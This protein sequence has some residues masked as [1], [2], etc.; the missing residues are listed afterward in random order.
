MLPINSSNGKNVRIEKEVGV[1]ALWM[2]SSAYMHNELEGG[3]RH[4]ATIQNPTHGSGMSVDR[5]RERM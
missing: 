1:R 2:S 4:G 3:G 5:G